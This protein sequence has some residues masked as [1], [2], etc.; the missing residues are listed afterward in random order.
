MTTATLFASAFCAHSGSS[1]IASRTSSANSSSSYG[2]RSRNSDSSGSTARSSRASCSDRRTRRSNSCSDSGS[3]QSASLSASHTVGAPITKAAATNTAAPSRRRSGNESL[4]PCARAMNDRP[5][6][7]AIPAAHMTRR[8]CGVTGGTIPWSTASSPSGSHSCQQ[9]QADEDADLAE[10]GAPLQRAGDHEALDL[11]RALV[12]LRDLG[13][14]EEALDR[15][16]LDVPVAAQHLDGLDGDRHSRVRAEELRHRRVLAH[17]AVAPVH[18]CACLV[19]QLAACRALRLHVGE[20]ELDRLEGG[21][22]LA[23]LAALLRVGGRV[24]GR[25]LGDSE[26]LG[27]DAEARMVKRA[28]RDLEALARVPDQVVGGHVDVL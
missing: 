28:H 4:K 7:S 12:D 13:V 19:E 3:F 17:V 15:V 25:A 20:L 11:V 18:L 23:E 21:D 16:L 5:R 2:S 26:G 8:S 6:E 1:S 10:L 22:R 24:V 27:P 14:A 9:R